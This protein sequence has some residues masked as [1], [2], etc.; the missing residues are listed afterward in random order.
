M[1]P[2][3]LSWC[4]LFYMMSWCHDVLMSWCHDVLMSWCRDVDKVTLYNVVLWSWF[5]CILM[6]WHIWYIYIWYVMV[7]RCDYYFDCYACAAL[8]LLPSHLL[9]MKIW[10]IVP[11]HD[12]MMTWWHD[13]MMTR[14]HD[15]T[16][17]WWH[18]DTMTCDTMTWWHD[19]MMT[20]WH[21]DMM[22][23]Q[24]QYYVTP[25]CHELD[26]DDIRRVMY[27]IQKQIP[28]LLMGRAEALAVSRSECHHY[29]QEHILS[30]AT[31]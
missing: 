9:L 12:D 29:F 16:M 8:A 24:T 10:I 18:D 26:S 7:Y 19:D 25:W 11:R 20:W 6:W 23:W 5:L 13:D 22:T 1:M 21:D 27:G 2:R 4:L 15:D 17:T 28:S 14:W 31:H 30:V 3:S